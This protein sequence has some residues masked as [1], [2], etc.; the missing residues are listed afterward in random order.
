MPFVRTVVCRTSRCSWSNP[1]QRGDGSNGMPLSIVAPD[2]FYPAHYRWK[3][4]MRPIGTKWSQDSRT[5]RGGKRLL[6][7]DADR[8]DIE[9]CQGVDR[10]G[11]DR[12][13]A[14]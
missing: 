1:A 11:P 10:F 6:P 2:T 7:G 13:E 14:T 3:S 5:S 4:M 8:R 9:C 12:A